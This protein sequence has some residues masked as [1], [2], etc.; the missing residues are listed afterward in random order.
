LF[1][2]L[3]GATENAA[4]ENAKP[5]KMQGWK[6]QDHHTGVENVRPAVME[7]RSSTLHNE[8]PHFTVGHKKRATFIFTITLGNVD[9][10]Q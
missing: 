4:P 10:F 7:R 5:S 2:A 3:Y 1:T 8:E 6:T 9:R